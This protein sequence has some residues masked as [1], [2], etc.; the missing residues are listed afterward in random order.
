MRKDKYEK[1]AGGGKRSLQF[2]QGN[3]DVP[4]LKPS[5]TALTISIGPGLP[6]DSSKIFSGYFL[7]FDHAVCYL[8][9]LCCVKTNFA[10]CMARGV[11]G[12][13]SKVY[14]G[15]LLEKYLTNF[16]Q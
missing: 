8:Q 5:R 12:A 2:V 13:Q 14:D 1:I 6:A 11:F 16:S 7:D 10:S 9:L 15:V 4:V 3:G